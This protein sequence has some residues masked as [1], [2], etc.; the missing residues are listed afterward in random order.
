VKNPA[1]QGEYGERVVGA[2]L[3][4]EPR[5][6]ERR[7]YRRCQEG[8]DEPHYSTG[9]CSVPAPGVTNIRRPGAVTMPRCQ[10]PLGT[11]KVSPR[12]M[13]V[14][15]SPAAVSSTMTIS[16]ESRVRISSPAGWRSQ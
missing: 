4:S 7:Q 1:E 13:A 10:T 5:R 11:M 16:P 3:G 12:L 9:L 2:V 8:Q 14:R 6:Q 15:C